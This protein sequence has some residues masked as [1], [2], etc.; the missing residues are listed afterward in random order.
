MAAT[1]LQQ[2][3][4]QQPQVSDCMTLIQVLSKTCMSLL[5]I[6]IYFINPR[7]NDILHVKSLMFVR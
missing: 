4:P 5:C 7:H 6:D 1:P 3:H 2:L